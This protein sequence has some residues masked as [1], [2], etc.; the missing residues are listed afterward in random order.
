LVDACA[1]LARQLLTASPALRIVATSRERLGVAGEVTWVV[2]PLST[3]QPHEADAETLMHYEAVR[4]FVDRARAAD[5]SF[6]LTDDDAPALARICRQL[7]GMPLALELAAARVRMLPLQQLA[8]RLSDRFALLVGGDR[9]A[10]ARQRTLR[11][12]IDWSYEQLSEPER[13]LLQRLS[14]F[15]GGCSLDAAEAVCCGG[16]V[17]SGDVLELLSGLVDKSLVVADPAGTEARYRLLVTIRDYAAQRLGGDDALRERHVDWCVALAERA[18]VELRS[19][20]AR[21]WLQRLEREHDN[22]RAALA[23]SLASKT[24]CEAGLRLAGSLCLFWGQ[25]G[26]LREG[27]RWLETALAAAPAAPPA[28]RALAL[29]GAGAL[30]WRLGD[31]ARAA[32][33]LQQSLVLRRELG[34]PLD[35]A[36]TLSMLG[37]VH[38]AQR[39]AGDLRRADACFSESLALA[40][41]T[42]DPLLVV[43]NL[44][45]LGDIAR[46]HGDLAAARARYGQALQASHGLGESRAAVILL[47]LGLVA[48]AQGDAH[49]ARDRFAQSLALHRTLG[50]PGGLAACLDGLAGVHAASGDARRAAQLLGAADAL[51]ASIGEPVQPTDCDDHERIVAAARARLDDA[52]FEAA[53]ASGARLTAEAAIELALAGGARDVD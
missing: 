14:V 25:R 8:E 37:V 24:R 21:P 6:E 9:T 3:P 27:A 30:A 26:H 46:L 12:A 4:L 48:F 36:R 16:S 11:A 13:T 35:T 22:L 7:D 28:V 18:D 29:H 10:P 43:H 23:W 39:T 15:A 32:T 34:V 44:N 47:N 45:A 33:L 31:G 38:S 41:A 2:P 5:P 50:E 49:D 42:G 40:D 20:G 52:S 53:C 19:A 1:G 17:A 51:R